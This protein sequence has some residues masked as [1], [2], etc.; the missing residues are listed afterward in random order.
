MVNREIILMRH[1]RPDLSSSQKIP[2]REMQDW[3]AQYDCAEIVDEQAPDACMTLAASASVIV[4]SSAPRARSSLQ[5]LGFEPDIVDDVFCEAQLPHT[6]WHHPR[7][8]PFTWAF[9]FRVL[10][11]CGFSGAA[12][13]VR[14]AKR[15]A[16][17]AAQR[18]QDLSSEGRVFL[19]GHGV[20]NRLIARHLEADGWTCHARSG[21]GYWSVMVYRRVPG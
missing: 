9:V 21:S 18:L 3:M 14:C 10:W 20:M 4:S 16:H 12:E 7:L 19:A 13:S 8:S 1:G 11:L 5:A 17:M 2:A 6:H 15:R